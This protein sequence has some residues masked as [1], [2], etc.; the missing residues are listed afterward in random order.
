[1]LLS[2]LILVNSIMER[3]SSIA[4]PL[5]IR[6][7]RILTWPVFILL[8]TMKRPCGKLN[9]CRSALQRMTWQFLCS[10]VFEKKHKK[11][12][13][14]TVG[15]KRAAES[16]PRPVPRISLGRQAKAYVESLYEGGATTTSTRKSKRRKKSLT[17]EEKSE[18]EAKRLLNAK[19]KYDVYFFKK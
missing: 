4:R 8:W 16:N 6:S 18:R 19:G 14:V 2:R 9:A 13:D 7:K 12:N 10:N 17:P 1:M 5:A 15:Q 11:N 3:F